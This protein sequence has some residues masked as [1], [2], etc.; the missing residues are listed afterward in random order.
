MPRQAVAVQIQ[1][2]VS[3][4]LPE[5][6]HRLPVPPAVSAWP[7]YAASQVGTPLS[8]AQ[9]WQGAHTEGAVV[10]QVPSTEQ[11]LRL[12]VSPEQVPQSL[13][14]VEHRYEVE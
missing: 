13:P 6:S 9:V 7:L 8:N 1:L 10:P 14:D 12:R 5:L 11:V 3:Q 4:P 2:L